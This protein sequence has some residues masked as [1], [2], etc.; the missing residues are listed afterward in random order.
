MEG[1]RESQYMDTDEEDNDF[2]ATL[3]IEFRNGIHVVPQKRVDSRGHKYGLLKRWR[4]PFKLR[5]VELPLYSVNRRQEVISYIEDCKMKNRGKTPPKDEIEIV[6]LIS[7]QGKAT[8]TPSKLVLP[9][10]PDFSSFVTEEG[11][12]RNLNLTLEDGERAKRELK[13]REKN[14][15]PMEPPELTIPCEDRYF[16]PISPSTSPHSFR[17]L[18]SV[19]S[20]ISYDFQTS[21]V[22]P[23][24]STPISLHTEASQRG[25]TF[26]EDGNPAKPPD[27]GLEF[28]TVLSTPQHS[29][30]TGGI[31]DTSQ[32]SMWP[33]TL[34]ESDDFETTSM[35][36]PT[37]IPKTLPTDI[38]DKMWP[39][40]A[41]IELSTPPTSNSDKLSDN[42][43]ILKNTPLDKERLAEIRER[44]TRDIHKLRLEG[45]EGEMEA[46]K[47]KKDPVVWDIDDETASGSA[48][49]DI[50]GG[51]KRLNVSDYSQGPS[52]NKRRVILRFDQ[53]GRLDKEWVEGSPLDTPS[54]D[55]T[56][57][58]LSP[59]DKSSTSETRTILTAKRG[60]VIRKC[61][62]CGEEN[63]NLKSHLAT[64]HLG[65]VWWGV[66]GDQTCW[67]CHDYHYPGDINKCD[68]HYLPLMHRELFIAR[69][70]EFMEYICEDLGVKGP[71]ELVARVRELGLHSRSKSSFSAREIYFLEEIDKFY[72]L[73]KLTRHSA[74]NPMRVSELFHWK[75]LTEIMVFLSEAGNIS[76][77]R[78]KGRVVS[79]VDARCDL[80]AIYRTE[81]H[82]GKL[83]SLP[84]V[85]KELARYPVNCVIGEVNDPSTEITNIVRLMTDRKV[86]V[87]LGVSPDKAILVTQ[88]YYDFCFENIRHS[89]VVGVGGLGIIGTEES[90]SYDN[91]RQVMID[92]IN[93]AVACSKA[94]RIYSTGNFDETLKIMKE[95]VQKEHPVHLLNFSGSFESA[96]QFLNSYHNGYIG[97]S[98]QI[99]DPSPALLNAVQLI[100]IQRIV[101]E[102]NCPNQP[103]SYLADSKPTDIVKII[104]T[105]S[106]IKKIDANLVAKHVRKNLNN[107]Y[108]F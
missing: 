73:P 56:L 79:I 65:K 53:E 11:D 72:S 5:E 93:M 95:N 63:K 96:D 61:R 105:L 30:N 82:D 32:S 25:T 108:H 107:L 76:G 62:I 106:C 104:N 50:T 89:R 92:Y 33:G 77:N 86:R 39:N 24:H 80:L 40:Q 58:D 87:A 1:Q 91:Q 21:V 100:P 19:K 101:V 75:T 103:I 22:T 98:G 59:P 16:L 46:K 41:P 85:K 29:T 27:A 17:D 2:P 99:C 55:L 26:N 74:S 67:R 97:L 45:E 52:P 68:G 23:R 35:Q 102:S 64:D 81:F 66:L 7:E 60:K 14:L 78:R 36:C 84:L 49:K 13:L 18:G 28:Q 10:K 37:K 4:D 69:H 44:V 12:I 3:H 57:P 51:M 90:I 9:L 83:D 94:V 8:P 48:Q 54:I 71:S 38:M 31:F 15:S 47:F 88:E 34:A 6:W 43:K 70:N 42:L 20:D